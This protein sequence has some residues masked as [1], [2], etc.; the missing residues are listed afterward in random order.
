[1]FAFYGK[2][3]LIHSNITKA[4]AKAKARKKGWIKF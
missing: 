4:K 3:N 1:M 2:T